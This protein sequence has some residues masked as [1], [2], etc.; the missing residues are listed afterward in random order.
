MV[1]AVRDVRGPRPES[2]AARHH[3]RRDARVWAQPKWISVALV[4][5]QAERPPCSGR[6]RVRHVAEGTKY[7]SC[8]SRRPRTPGLHSGYAGSNPARDTR[9][10]NLRGAHAS[11][12]EIGRNDW[13]APEPV[14]GWNDCLVNSAA[15]VPACLVGSRGFDSRTRRQIIAEIAQTVERRVEGACVGGS[16]PSLGT[17][18]SLVSSAG[19]RAPV[20][21]A[22]GRTFDSCTRRQP[23]R[24]SSIGRAAASKAE[25]SRFDPV[26]RCQASSRRSQAAEGI[27]L[28]PRR[29]KPASV[30][31]GPSSPRLVSSA[32]SEQPAS[33]R[34]VGRSNRSR[35]PS[36]S[37]IAQTAERLAV[38]QE[39]RGSKPRR[40]ASSSE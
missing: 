13:A 29:R 14:T 25:G 2:R 8:S 40:G 18:T 12:V 6:P 7:K 10:R 19:S 26:A 15:R 11:R 16:K 5:Q 37:P 22:G 4:A 33:N 35:G 36:H 17:R 21:E 31:I 9:A 34:Q 27:W 30:R 28:Q 3:I 39:V 32:D 24:A 1:L 20:Y 38:N 23:R